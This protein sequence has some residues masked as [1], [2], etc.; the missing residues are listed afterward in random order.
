[1]AHAIGKSLEVEEIKLPEELLSEYVGV[2][3]IE[4]ADENRVIR[5]E[6]GHLVSQRGDNQQFGIYPYAKD[7]FAYENL[8]TRMEVTR[9]ADGK[10]SGHYM[11]TPQGDKS[12]AMLTDDK[13]EAPE[14]VVVPIE[15]LD[16]YIGKYE[17]MPDFIL[18]VSR[19]DDRLMAQATGQAAFMLTPRDQT[20]FVVP[21]VGA[22]IEFQVQDSGDCDEL[23]L[24]QG[25]QTM[26]AP[27]MSDE[28]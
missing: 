28:R 21:Q 2:Y 8:L 10:I 23:I 25:G 27:R 18:T 24:Y 3:A 11:L 12:F 1:M 7:K 4:D 9:G 6:D 22:R 13:V 15:V 19:Q 26:P 5:L 14:V 20:T 16:K 17:L